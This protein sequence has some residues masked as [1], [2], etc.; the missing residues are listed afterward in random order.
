MEILENKS[1]MNWEFE[2]IAKHT[3]DILLIVDKNQMIKF[4]TP[5]IES[6]LGYRPEECLGGNA[7]EPV[8]AEDRDQLIA[9]YRE[10]IMTKEPKVNEY[11]VFHKNGELKFFES[12][13]MPVRNHPDHLVVVS[14]R[15]ITFRKNMEEELENRKNRYQ[16]LQNKLINFSQDLSTTMKISDLQSRLINELTNTIPDSEPKIVVYHHETPNEYLS[17]GLSSYVPVLAIGKLHYDQEQIHILLGER[18]EKAYILTIK[19]SSIKESMDSIWFETV[20]YYTV[21]VFESLNVIENLMN[22]LETALQKSERPQWILRLLFNLSEKQRME[23]SSDLHDTVLQDQIASYRKLETILK[24]HPFDYDVD[25]QLKGILQGLLD[26]IHQIKVT[27]NELRPPLLRE[28]GLIGALENLFDHT[29][30]S[31]PFKIKFTTENT[32]GLQLNE[33][34]TIGIL[35]HRTGVT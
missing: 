18:K 34:E 10:V 4:V 3:L 19:A 16:E 1:G 30:V 5:S 29:Q 13:V 25:L 31:A 21:M 27:C 2:T 17:N 7:F 26:T 20:V 35:P 22:Q 8:Y 6:I 32:E 14:I 15:D 23:L 12:R 24:E 33:E 28:L 9:D 11:R